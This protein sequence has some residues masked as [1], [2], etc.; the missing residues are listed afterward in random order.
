M[1]LLDCQWMCWLQHFS[2]DWQADRLTDTCIYIYMYIYIQ[3]DQWVTLYNYWYTCFCMINLTCLGGSPFYNKRERFWYIHNFHAEEHVGTLVT[4]HCMLIS[5]VHVKLKPYH[6]G[7]FILWQN[8]SKKVKGRTTWIVVTSDPQYDKMYP[9]STSP[10]ITFLDI[11]S[12]H[13]RTTSHEAATLAITEMKAILA[14]SKMW[15]D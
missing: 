4:R 2:L 12:N 11:K 5:T 9:V 15:V 13:N 7:S 10:K 3:C 14:N 8:L 6:L 1:L